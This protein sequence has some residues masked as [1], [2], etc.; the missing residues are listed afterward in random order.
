MSGFLYALSE[1]TG[2]TV[3]KFPA[4]S[5]LSTQPAAVNGVVYVA[6]DA[7]GMY[8]VDGETGDERWFAPH[9]VQFCSV[10]A[11]HVY[12]ID[13]LDHL[14][15]LDSQRGTRLATLPL[16]D[17]QIKML[18]QQTDRIYLASDT[19]VVQC[20]H[21]LGQSKPLVYAPPRLKRNTGKSDQR[22]RDEDKADGEK[23]PEDA[24][25]DAAAGEMPADENADDAAVDGSEDAS[26][27]AAEGD[28]MTEEKEEADPKNPF[29]N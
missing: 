2:E 3:W 9:I 18:N 14:V 5:T 22:R 13:N 19:G 24:V 11:S 17:V 16:G 8:A 29:N 6:A 21:E 27:D 12:A 26:A 15:I 25:D 20:L 4:G 28:A 23:K 1:E 10:S 7:G